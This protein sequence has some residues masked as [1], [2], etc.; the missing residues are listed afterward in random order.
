MDLFIFGE[1]EKSMITALEI[2]DKGFDNIIDCD[3]MK[4]IQVLEK[5][6]LIYNDYTFEMMIKNNKYC[7]TT[8]FKLSEQLQR[9]FVSNKCLIIYLKI[10]NEN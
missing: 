2:L 5:R 3:V 7:N 8:V 4:T 1:S 10:L 9:L 6:V